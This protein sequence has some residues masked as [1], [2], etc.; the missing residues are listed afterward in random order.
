MA[1]VVLVGVL[2]WVRVRVGGDD[3]LWAVAGVA[4]VLLWVAAV[5]FRSRGTRLRRALLVTGAVVLS[6]LLVVGG[7]YGWLLV[8]NM[9]TPAQTARGRGTDALW[10]GHAWVDGRRSQTDIDALVGR[11]RQAGIRDLYVHAGPLADDGS[12]DPSLRPTANRLIESVHRAAPTVRVQAWL[13]NVVAADRLR[14]DDPATRTRVLDS[15]TR[16]LADGFDGIHYDFEPVAE[17]S[18]GFLDVLTGTRALTRARNAVLSVA[19]N[20]LEP[21]PGAHIPGQVLFGRPHWW[22]VDYF[23][24]VARAVDQIAIMTY[25]TGIPTEGAYSGYFSVQ[26]RLAVRVVPADVD[27]VLGI[28]A[29]HEIEA[30]HTSAETVAPA[31]RGLRLALGDDPP[32]RAVGAALYVDVTATDDDWA[33]YFAGWAGSP[34]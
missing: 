14:L 27:L 18:R 15:A 2:C 11:V 33:Q 10:L 25:D 4:V 21:I 29:Y 28:P 26:T 9:G 23:G 12:L 3:W 31:L 34:R 8:E 1:V 22:S 30:M 32:G 6:P 13:G 20:Q 24:Q 16:V 17:G 5:V 19:T 7:M